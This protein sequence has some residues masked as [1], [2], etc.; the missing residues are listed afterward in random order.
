MPQHR[1]SLL[2][3][4]LTMMPCILLRRTD[5]QPSKLGLVAVHGTG[6]PLGDPIEVGAL[7]QALGDDGRKQQ[8]GGRSTA[9]EK[10]HR[11]ALASVKSCY[12]HTEG[13]AGLTGA[14]L[15]VQ[16]LQAQVT[17][18]CSTY[19]AAY[20]R[21]VARLLHC[22]GTGFKQPGVVC[23][24][25]SRPLLSIHLLVGWLATAAACALARLVPSMT[26]MSAPQAVAPVL[27]CHALNPY[28][29]SALGD[30]GKLSTRRTAHV[31]RIAVAH[32]AAQP[33]P[34]AGADIAYLRA[35]RSC[36]SLLLR[37]REVELLAH[38]IADRCGADL[39]WFVAP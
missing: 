27:N 4:T 17:S 39:Q 6:T 20:L 35:L 32:P 15:A 5:V 19:V 13:A 7:G 16:C 28:V 29:S 26:V 18:I 11:V 22:H 34:A 24:I 12:G 33:S 8:P 31:P 23:A 14:L 3:C 2:P 37:V 25:I 38:S 36:N 9:E 1:R 10:G 21:H 30:W